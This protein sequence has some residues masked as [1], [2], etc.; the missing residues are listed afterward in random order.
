M[1]GR[2]PF[3][4]MEIGDSFLI[5]P[6]IK[7]ISVQVAALRFKRKTGKQFAFRKMPDG[8]RCWRIK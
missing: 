3:N 6:D 2:Y 1:P 4:E 8:V 7:T 5:S